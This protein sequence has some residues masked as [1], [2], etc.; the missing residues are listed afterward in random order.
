[1]GYCAGWDGIAIHARHPTEDSMCARFMRLS[2][3]VAAAQ[4]I[5]V[6]RWLRLGSVSLWLVACRNSSGRNGACCNGACCTG[7]CCNGD[8]WLQPAVCTCDVIEAKAV[9]KKF[10][11]RYPGVP[12]STLVLKYRGVPWS[13]LGAL[14][15]PG[16]KVPWSTEEYPEG[17]CGPCP[18]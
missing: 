14:E 13:T 17:M 10:P 3:S 8:C 2:R 11:L 7:A 4:S 16:P 12:L 18:S 15:Y 1:M 9:G 5:G 6:S